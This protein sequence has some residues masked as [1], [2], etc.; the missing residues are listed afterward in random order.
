M[1][2]D[3]QEASATYATHAQFGESVAC[4]KVAHEVDRVHAQVPH[5]DGVPSALQQQQIIKRLRHQN[6][7]LSGLSVLKAYEKVCIFTYKNDYI[8]FETLENFLR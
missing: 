5:V 3:E 4:L 6:K 2:Q 7:Q 8:K 1:D